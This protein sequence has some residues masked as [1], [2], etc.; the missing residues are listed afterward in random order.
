MPQMAPISWVTI[1]MMMN[2]TLMTMVAK[3]NFKSNIKNKKNNFL[4]K[5]KMNW[6]W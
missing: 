6:K 3:L 4:K 5:N 2:F 1:M